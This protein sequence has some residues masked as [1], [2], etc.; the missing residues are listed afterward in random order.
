M[1]SKNIIVVG[2][3]S[4]IVFMGIASYLWY[5]YFHEYEEK[6]IAQ[7]NDSD[8]T[9][10]VELIN[11]GSIT[12]LNA[13]N[14]DDDMI[15]PTYY[16]RVKNNSSMD[17]EYVL[18]LENAQVNDGCSSATTYS[19]SELEYELKLDNRVIKTGGLDTI[20]NNVLDINKVT[21]NSINDY[22]I[23]VRLKS[24]VTDYSDKHFHYIITMKE[25]K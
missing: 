7:N 24:S 22:S 6:L 5:L 8:F 4:L 1:K 12:Y 13:T 20:S 11:S 18:Y 16:F 3:F 21:K 17:H 23:K 25:K 14:T 19:R 10:G 2:I 9:R 15:V